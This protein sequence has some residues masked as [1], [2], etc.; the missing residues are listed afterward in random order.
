MDL[1]GFFHGSV[2][3]IKKIHLSGHWTRDGRFARPASSVSL[4]ADTHDTHHLNQENHGK[5]TMGETA[6]MGFVTWDLPKETN[7]VDK[8]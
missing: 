8:L 1:L 3:F 7:C 5:K 2:I 6:F 4:A